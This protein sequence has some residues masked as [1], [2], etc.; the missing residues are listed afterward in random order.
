MFRHVPIPVSNLFTRSAVVSR[1]VHLWVQLKQPLQSLNH[2]LAEFGPFSYNF[3]KTAKRCLINLEVK[4]E[5]K[6]ERCI[7][8]SVAEALENHIRPGLL[9]SPARRLEDTREFIRQEISW[10][11]RK[12]KEYLV[13]DRGYN[14]HEAAVPLYVLRDITKAKDKLPRTTTLPWMMFTAWDSPLRM[15]AIMTN[16]FRR[17]KLQ[18]VSSFTFF[19]RYAVVPNANANAEARSDLEVLKVQHI[20]NR[21]SSGPAREMIEWVCDYMPHTWPNVLL[22]SM[23]E[24][25][26]MQLSPHSNGA[27]VQWTFTRKIRPDQAGMSRLK[28]QELK[29]IQEMIGYYK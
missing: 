7:T 16:A 24:N 18:G 22:R 4:N 29:K 2:K 8:C 13:D 26:K 1:K 3:G 23:P 27:Q 6:V 11:A 15:K 12:A 10:R 25:T 19:P 20:K 21:N 28:D 17:L 5:E 9:L 14:Y